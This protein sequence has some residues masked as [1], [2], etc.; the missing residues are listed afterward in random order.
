MKERVAMNQ[1][2]MPLGENILVSLE[3]FTVY[4]FILK[5]KETEWSVKWIRSN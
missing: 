2:I 4:D 1:L 3:P 5:K